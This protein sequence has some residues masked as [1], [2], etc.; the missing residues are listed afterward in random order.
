MKIANVNISLP[1]WDQKL[2]IETLSIN[3]AHNQHHS[4]Q[5]SAKIPTDYKLSLEKLR[6]ILGETLKI[7]VD[8][9]SEDGKLTFSG[10]VDEVIPGWQDSSRILVVKG[11]SKTVFLD[12]APRF[13]GFTQ[14]SLGAIFNTICGEYASQLDTHPTNVGEKVSYAIQAH[15]TDYQFLSRLAEIHGKVLYFDG[16]TLHLGDMAGNAAKPLKLDFKSEAKA[17]SISL[18]LAPIRFRVSGFDQKKGKV[19][20]FNAND[21]VKSSHTLVKTVI[22]K[23]DCYPARNIHINHLVES[24]KNDLQAIARNIAARQAHELVILN[25]R[26][27]NPAIRIGSTIQI[28]ETDELIGKGIFVVIGVNHTI[29]RNNT[30]TNSFSAVPAGFPFSVSMGNYAPPQSGPV[31][32]IVRENADPDKLGRVKVELIGDEEKSISPWIRVLVP[33][34]AHG[35][36]Y[37]LPEKG[38]HVMLFFEDFK[39]EASPFVM[40]SFYQGSETAEKWKDPNNKKKGI[41]TDK[42]SLL[43]DDNNGKL[44]IVADEI[45]LKARKDMTLEGGSDADFK[46][47]GGNMKMNGTK[48]VKINGGPIL[49]LKGSRIELN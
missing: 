32:A 35:G 14:K 26:S 13:R 45:E 20:L 49:G 29:S 8:N 23:S 11:F 17:A 9:G 15:E 1:G 24:K 16:E 18:N 25:G 39:M 2:D 33:Y 47:K 19:E 30:Y 43:F 36:M 3:Q 44:T 34:T 7:T 5:F 41:E 42:I 28:C 37:F 12:T 40:G 21:Q 48:Q 22:E 46:L 6:L 38:D 27:N 31:A 4:F 10:F